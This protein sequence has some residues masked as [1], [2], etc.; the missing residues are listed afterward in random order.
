VS[1]PQFVPR[2]G[3]T[4][5]ISAKRFATQWPPLFLRFSSAFR[6]APR[7]PFRVLALRD[8]LRKGVLA[9][10]AVWA[11][12]RLPRSDAFPR[13]SRRDKTVCSIGGPPFHLVSMLHRTDYLFMAVRV[14]PNRILCN[15]HRSISHCSHSTLAQNRMSSGVWRDA[16]TSAPKEVAPLALYRPSSSISAPP[17]S[18]WRTP[19]PWP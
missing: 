3:S 1:S 11:P 17:C 2:P 4:S 15:R 8:D 10:L 12:V 7:P 9:V 13:Y 6:S 5:L 14:V 18:R 16:K 19:R